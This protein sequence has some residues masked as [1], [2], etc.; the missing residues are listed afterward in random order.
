MKVAWSSLYEEGKSF[1]LWILRDLRQR[2]SKIQISLGTAC[3][4]KNAYKLVAFVILS[5][6]QYLEQYPIVLGPPTMLNERMLAT[7]SNP[8]YHFTN[9]NPIPVSFPSSQLPSN[10]KRSPLTL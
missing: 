7:L 1:R 8:Q 6:A 5:P 2:I 3:V 10:T 4:G 9:G